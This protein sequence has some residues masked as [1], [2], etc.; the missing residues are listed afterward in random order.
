MKRNP[1]SSD[2]HNWSLPIRHRLLSS[3]GSSFLRLG[4]SPLLEIKSRK[5][6]TFSRESIALISEIIFR[7]LNQNILSIDIYRQNWRKRRNCRES[8]LL[9]FTDFKQH[10]RH[11][12][13]LKLPWD[14][15]SNTLFPLVTA[16]TSQGLFFYF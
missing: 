6:R 11:Y 2:L 7:T 15:Y 10:S 13:V 14:S 5:A 9:S 8:G 12:I 1:H 4:L 3:S 16:Y